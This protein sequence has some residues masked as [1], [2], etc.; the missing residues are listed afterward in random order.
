[1]L[2]KFMGLLVEI[3]IPTNDGTLPANARKDFGTY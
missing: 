1:M 2:E 3:L